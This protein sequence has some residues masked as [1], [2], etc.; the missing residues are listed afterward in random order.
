MSDIVSRPYSKEGEEA[1]DRVFGKKENENRE[2]EE[3]EINE[4]ICSKG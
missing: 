3:R 1:Y 4:N 2:N